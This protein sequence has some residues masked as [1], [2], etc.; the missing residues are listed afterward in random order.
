[1]KMTLRV[2]MAAVASVATGCGMVSVQDSPG[3]RG[4]YFDGDLDYAT[5][6]GAIVTIIAGNPFGGSKAQFDATVR[7]LM[8]G[9]NRGVPADFVAQPGARTD[10]LYK[11]VVAFDLAPGVSSRRMC[12]S[13]GGLQTRPQPGRLDMRIAFCIGD[14]WKSGTEG[15]V[16]GV[17]GLADA[18]FGEL[19]RQATLAM[20][21]AQDGH[22][23]GEG[24]GG[25]GGVAN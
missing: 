8:K 24:D 7:Q 18:R 4:S 3:P 14:E 22:E 16:R 11:V 15:T 9:Q 21:P 6:E 23:Q 13:P 1:M 17:S 19:V 20:I 5:R 25:G 2:A 10:P 12:E